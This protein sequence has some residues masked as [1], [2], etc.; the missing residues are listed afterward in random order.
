MEKRRVTKLGL[1]CVTQTCQLCGESKLQNFSDPTS[2]P[3]PVPLYV[4]SG[5]FGVLPFR[6]GVDLVARHKPIVAFLNNDNTVAL[7]GHLKWGNHI[8]HREHS[9][10]IERGAIHRWWHFHLSRRRTTAHRRGL[11]NEVTDLAGG[12]PAEPHSGVRFA[13]TDPRASK[14]KFSQCLLDGRRAI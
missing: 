7:D 10:A 5:R 6:V 2:E 12:R 3:I 13:L 11:R 1:V 9:L 8:R 4:P 14:V